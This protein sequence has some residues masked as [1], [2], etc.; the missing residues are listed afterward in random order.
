MIIYF[1]ITSLLNWEE[2]I[3]ATAT[4]N[5]FKDFSYSFSQIIVPKKESRY[6]Y[7][8][9]IP[10]EEIKREIEKQAKIYGND[11][12]FM[13]NLADC[14]SDFNNFADN[15]KSSALGIYQYLDGTWR[16]TESWKKYHLSRTDYKANIKEAMIDIANGEYF[17][18]AECIN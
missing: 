4:K 5:F 3:I 11:I 16:E 18:W 13:I 15:K 9:K 14:E 6:L 10:V 7:N 2:K 1:N 8:D 17:R 12:D